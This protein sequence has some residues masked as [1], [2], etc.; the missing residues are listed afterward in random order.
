M[1]QTTVFPLIM[2][3]ISFTNTNLPQG[4]EGQLFHMTYNV[5]KLIN[6]YKEKLHILKEKNEMET[7]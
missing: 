7:V 5:L 6:F 1:P 2:F 3:Q 4:A